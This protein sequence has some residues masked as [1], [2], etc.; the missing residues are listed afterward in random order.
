MGWAFFSEDIAGWSAG[1]TLEL[2]LNDGG[3]G[4]VNAKNLKLY[5]DVAIL[6]YDEAV[7]VDI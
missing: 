7:P 3:A 2:W 5:S 6:T 1:D 4:T